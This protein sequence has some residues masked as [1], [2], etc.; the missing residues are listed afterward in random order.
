M[1]TVS[2]LLLVGLI[3]GAWAWRPVPP[4]QAQPGRSVCWDPAVRSQIETVYDRHR[5]A[6]RDARNRVADERYALWRLLLSPQATRQQLEA[7]AARLREAQAALQRA[8]LGFLVDLRESAPSDRREQ[9]LRC[10]LGRGWR[11]LR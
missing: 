6:L 3:L 9:V 1:R 2:R 7:Q 11:F 10:A 8:W 5:T 4:A